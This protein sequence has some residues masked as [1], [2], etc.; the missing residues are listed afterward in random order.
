MNNHGST[1]ITSVSIID[2]TSPSAPPR[3][4]QSL[5]DVRVEGGVVSHVVRAGSSLPASSR[6][7]EGRGCFISPGFVDLHVHLR[8]PG[9]EESE[10]IETGSRAAARGGFTAIV[11]MPN[12]EPTQDSR[13]V[14][15]FVR[16]RASEVGLCDVLPAGAI[17]LA[18]AGEV[19]SPMAELRDAGVQ[20]FTDDAQVDYSTAGGPVGSPKDAAETFKGMMAMFDVSI[21]AG[22]NVAIEFIDADSAKVRSIYIM[23]LRIPGADGAQPNYMQASGWYDDVIVR[24]ANGWR[25]K[26]RFEQ[27]VYAKPA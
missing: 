3:S 23:T 26:K 6:T 20:I 11:A 5:F 10:T 27:L 12:T 22:G 8:E 19:L 15:E 17:T 18:R 13:A 21:S 2:S 4:P 1:T 24:T 9:Q 7:L 16:S 25:I 14:V